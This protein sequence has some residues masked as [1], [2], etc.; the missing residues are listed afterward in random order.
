MTGT[1]DKQARTCIIRIVGDRIEAH[2]RDPRGR[3]RKSLVAY[4]SGC[5]IEWRTDSVTATIG[6]VD[7]LDD[8]SAVLVIPVQ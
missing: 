4:V 3:P 2:W 1:L 5:A 8:G 7:M 6:T